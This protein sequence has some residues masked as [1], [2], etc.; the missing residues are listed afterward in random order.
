MNADDLD[1]A[2]RV[3]VAALGEVAELDW[4]QPAIGTWNANETAS[5]VARSFLLYA[6]QIARGRS[7]ATL[8]FGIAMAPKA[9][10]EDRVAV[11]DAAGGILSTVI[12]GA[13]PTLRAYH[14]CGITDPDGFA[15]LGCAEI[16]LHTYDIRGGL[17]LPWTIPS[18][19][20]RGV[21]VRLVPDVAPDEKPT[22]QLLWATGRIAD[23]DLGER[24]EWHWDSRVRPA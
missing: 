23:S 21:L 11:I 12:R 8:P 20:S 7:G 4:E 19:L 1:S 22:D 13:A 18:D 14:P 16:L 3:S 17:G 6:G 9:T 2:V 24:G 5:H 10:A 15:A